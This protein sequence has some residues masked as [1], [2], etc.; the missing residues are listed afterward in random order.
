MLGMAQNV[1]MLHTVVVR[2]GPNMADTVVL[3]AL[4]NMERHNY[5]NLPSFAYDFYS[6]AYMQRKGDT[7][8]LFF[9]ESAGRHL[10]LAPDHE[11][12][13]VLATRT[14]GTRKKIFA[15]MLTQLQSASF[16]GKE[17]DFLEMK[18]V[19]PLSEGT[20]SRYFFMMDDT[21]Y[22]SGDT[23]YVIFFRPRQGQTFVGLTGRMTISSRGYALSRIEARPAG[24][25]SNLFGSVASGVT[26]AMSFCHQFGCD[27]AGLWLPRRYV[28]SFEITVPPQKDMPH[29]ETIVLTA[30]NDFVDFKANEPLTMKDFRNADDVEVDA[31]SEYRDTAFWQAYRSAADDSVSRRRER[32]YDLYDSLETRLD[33]SVSL[34]NMLGFVEA[35]ADGYIPLWQSEGRPVGVNIDINRLY[36]RNNYE[37]ARLGLG[38]ELYRYLNGRDV[39]LALLAWGAYGLA[40]RRWKEGV[41]LG[42]ASTKGHRLSAS[43]YA[44]NTVEPFANS[45]LTPYELIDISN[46]ANY[47]YTDMMQVRRAGFSLGWRQWRRWDMLVGLRV[48]SEDCLFAHY[49]PSGVDIWKNVLYREGLL[50]IH[51]QDG[52]SKL[53]LGGEGVGSLS[54]TQ[55]PSRASA[56]VQLLAGLCPDRVEPHGMA[57]A[58]YHVPYLR[59]LAQYD[60]NLRLPRRGDL[61]V[62]LHG[63][64][65]TPS[66][67]ATRLFLLGGTAASRYYY[68][69]SF[70]TLPAG[71]FL[72]TAFVQGSVSFVFERPLWNT[73]QWWA[74]L[75]S[76]P[77]LFVQATAMAASL[78]SVHAGSAVT[79]ILPHAPRGVLAEPAIGLDG[80]LRWK[81]L[82]A[83]VV[84]A[85]NH[86][87]TEKN[88]IV[89]F[90]DNI[91]VLYSLNVRID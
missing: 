19:N 89:Q 90:F 80:L 14:T 70:L 91:S 81:I 21:L 36:N 59:L 65:A 2:P 64:V 4:A 61:I 9:S 87:K 76:R 31:R 67:P 33:A 15:S 86:K 38:G 83:G 40:D 85:Y 52:I 43:L 53:T 3:R 5:H 12:E 51:W 20:L 24:R 74:A 75:Y 63:G 11:R 54:L 73:R 57:G 49:M 13:V 48:S 41:A 46:N 68:R 27:S 44:D 55:R 1:R 62:H 37:G 23:S 42:A 25:Y 47:C 77:F 30:V 72:A 84:L 8:F 22:T 88:N 82:D 26:T 17:I 60:A 50:A 28:T 16:Y 69:N 29:E 66:T 78:H 35:L 39:K 71:A 79:P 56:D 34:D 6:Q 45:S 10:Y 58:S 32:C 7:S 18:F